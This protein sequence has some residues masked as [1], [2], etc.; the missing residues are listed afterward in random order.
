MSELIQINALAPLQGARKTSKVMLLFPPEW[1]PTA[2]YLA[3]PSLTAVLRQAGHQVVQ[4]DI[5]IEMYDHFFSD[6]FLIWIKARQT[7]QLKALEAKELRGELTDKEM[8]QQAALEQ[9]ADVDLFDL[10]ERAEESKVVVRG[11]QFYEAEKLET[12]LNCFRE[13]M[14]YIS[15]AYYPASLV[16]YPMESNLGYRPG[17]SKEVF[18]CL[19]DEQVNIYRDICNQ[20]VMPAVAKEKP[21]DVHLLIVQ[22]GEHFFRNAR[23]IA[24]VTF[25]RIEHERRRIV[26]GGNVGHHLAEAIQRCFELFR[27][28]ELWAPDHDLRLFRPLCQIEQVHVRC[29]LQRRLLVRFL[30][31]QFP[32]QFLCHQ[33]LQLHDLAG[34]D[35]DQKLHA[36][37][38]FVHLDIDVALHYVMPRLA[39]DGS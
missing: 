2:P 5:N 4:R 35:P 24:Q 10:A 12:S 1:V 21:I 38:V 29:L 16:F 25:H 13:V 8:D 15:T 36:E 3:L 14:A 26:G 32:S 27:L 22:T 28:V 37:E 18:A 9:V 17:V 34:L 19:D 20:L 7:M 11:P 39:E 31:G 23:T 30:V 33:G 6:S